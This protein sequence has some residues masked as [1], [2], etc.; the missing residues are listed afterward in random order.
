MIRFF[1]AL[2]IVASFL[3]CSSKPEKK[4][5]SIETSE[6]TGEDLGPKDDPSDTIGFFT[7][8]N[9]VLLTKHA[10]HRLVPVYKVNTR[11]RRR[12]K[13]YYIGSNSFHSNY[14]SYSD[15]D[16]NNWNYNFMPGFEAMYGHGLVNVYH[17]DVPSKS[18]SLFFKDT[19]LI[20][21]LYYPTFSKDSLNFEPVNR[22]Y[23][24]VS[25]YNEDSNGDNRISRRDLRRFFLFDINGDLNSALIP[26]TYSV[27]S[28]RYD[29]DN[30]FMYV[31]AAL[32][33]N[34]NGQMEV[35]EPVHIF[36]I[37]LKDPSQRGRL[38]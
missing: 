31:Y 4:G 14:W 29:P 26:P 33:E 8:P 25:V 28:S 9:H 32:D 18:A 36:W 35:T 11:E 3:S 13:E 10:D 7:Q 20:N 19:V 2:L 30:D 27:R 38:Y 21:T 22:N 16:G 23:Y 12:S 1:S 24:M 5:A 37:N 34:E 17:F 6:I 15:G